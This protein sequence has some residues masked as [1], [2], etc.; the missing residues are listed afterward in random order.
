MQTPAVGGFRAHLRLPG[1]WLRCSPRS[2]LF[3]LRHPS[4]TELRWRNGGV[5]F[6]DW[7]VG[8][9]FSSAISLC[10]VDA[11]TVVKPPKA[12]LGGRTRRP[13]LPE[14]D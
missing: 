9:P 11:Q 14:D 10:A 12:A 1:T 3:S 13:V 8:S 2:S 4:N 7:G 5:V 6:L